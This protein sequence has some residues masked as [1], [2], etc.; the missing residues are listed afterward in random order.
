[1]WYRSWGQVTMD[2]RDKTYSVV[3]FPFLKTSRPVRLGS[4]DFR[5]TDDL[6]GLPED[7]SASVTEIT[8]MLFALGNQ[9]IRC[10]SYATVDRV[11]LG[12]APAGLDALGDIEAVVAYLYASPRHEFNDLFL[13]PE[14]TSIVVLTPNRV[15]PELVRLPFNVIDVVEHVDLEADAMGFVDELGSKGV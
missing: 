5:S 1:M 15:I 2:P 7:Q 10:A 3:V 9:R 6:D 14:H 13:T 11:D 12:N 8:G 4:L